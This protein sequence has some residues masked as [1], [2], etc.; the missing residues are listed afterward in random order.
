MTTTTLA[1]VGWMTTLRGIGTDGK[2]LIFNILIPV[3]C[4]IFVLVVGFRTKSPGPTIMAAILATVLWGLTA[5]MATLK[6]KSVQDINQYSGTTSTT[7][8]KGDQ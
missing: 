2:D 3:L 4:G 6:D 1:A 8:V 5:N 7:S